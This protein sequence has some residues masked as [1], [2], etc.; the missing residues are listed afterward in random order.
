MAQEEP[1]VA[2]YDFLYRDANRLASYYAQIFGS[3]L[4]SIEDSDAT[5]EAREK[6]GEGKVGA[7]GTG[8]GG[9]FKHV[10]DVQSAAKRTADLGKINNDVDT[11][12][13]GSIVSA[14]GTLAFV[15]KS[16]LE[17]G[18]LV[19]DSQIKDEKKKHGK[20]KQHSV[21]QQ[22]ELVK[23]FLERTQ[24]PSAFVLRS[25]RNDLIVGTI[26]EAGLE[27][28]I[29]TYYFKHGTFGLANV[30]LIGIKELPSTSFELPATNLIGMGTKAAKALHDMLFPAA[31][32][33]VT[34]LAMFRVL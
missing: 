5:R 23:S 3:H 10:D 14:E 9:A 19:I 32:I 16:M 33:K 13:H 31:S 26:K 28:P 12:P 27:E 11:A 24:L 4:V 30:H 6:S 25:Q 21:I 2:L 34:P 15:D 29:T 17:M 20:E 22:L 8:V 1:A 18:I 7:L